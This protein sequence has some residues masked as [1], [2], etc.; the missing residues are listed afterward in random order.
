M[1]HAFYALIMTAA[2]AAR[3]VHAAE[4]PQ[5]VATRHIDVDAI[6]STALNFPKITYGVEADP[7]TIAFNFPK[8]TYGVDVDSTTTIA[9]NYTKIVFGV[10]PTVT[11]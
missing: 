5:Q 1:K 8:I 11:A 2:C 4:D 3:A 9:L 6:T 10:G 7:T